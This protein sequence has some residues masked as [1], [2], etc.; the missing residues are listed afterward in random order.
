[1][2]AGCCLESADQNL[3]KPLLRQMSAKLTGGYE[4]K[5]KTIGKYRTG[6]NL[7]EL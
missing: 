5:D 6:K 1:M 7:E 2:E 3:M 4:R